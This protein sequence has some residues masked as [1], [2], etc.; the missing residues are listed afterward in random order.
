MK[1]DEDVIMEFFLEYMTNT[2]STIALSNYL[3]INCKKCRADSAEMDYC[4]IVVYTCYSYSRTFMSRY[5][6]RYACNMN[7]MNVGL[8]VDFDFLGINI[9]CNNA[10]Q[11]VENRV[12][13][14]AELRELASAESPD[15]F[16]LVYTNILDHQP[17]CPVSAVLQSAEYYFC[18]KKK[19]ITGELL[20][21]FGSRR[22][23]K[24]W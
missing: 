13:V 24:N 20:L 2:V 22:L 19:K 6:V 8:Y 1:L 10:V 12:K 15:T 23:L 3:Y 4:N 17:D 16:T 5:L 7:V 14:L 11:K 9:T 21:F 18:L